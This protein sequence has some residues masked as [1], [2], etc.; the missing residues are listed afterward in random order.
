MSP[1]F[2]CLVM[3]LLLAGCGA[4][5]DFARPGTWRAT[6][7]ND[8]NLA[9]MLANPGDAVRGVAARTERGQ[10]A[11]LAIRRLEQGRRQPLPDSRAAAIGEV[12]GPAGA[13]P[14]PTGGR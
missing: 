11:S 3:V 14:E 9:V 12:S 4:S 8:A 5:G 13:M 2:P 10:P 1:R 6:G 7:A